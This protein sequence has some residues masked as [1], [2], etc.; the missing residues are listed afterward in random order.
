MK[1]DKNLVVI[2]YGGNAMLNDGLTLK[3]LKTIVDFFNDGFRIIIVHGGGPF[4]KRNLKLAGIQSEFVDGHR[5]TDNNSMKYVE[6]ALK[7]EVNGKLVREINNLGVRAVGLSGKDGKLATA[8]KRLHYNEKK[9]AID[10][11]QVGNVK[12]IFPQIID[13]LISNNFLPVVTSIASGDDG[14]DYN[15]NAD[16]FAGHLAG[17]LKADKF[18]LLTDVDGLMRNPEN[19]DTLIPELRIEEIEKL[20]NKIIKGGMLPKTEACKLALENGAKMAMIIN[21]T[22]PEALQNAVKNKNEFRG[23]IFLT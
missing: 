4:I 18:I 19:Q 23:T 3:L 11:G 17:K 12:D 1:M 9:E 6:M 8:V 21:G 15:I 5:K 10:L 13:L 2:K 16:M 22:K 20:K 14:I 7:G